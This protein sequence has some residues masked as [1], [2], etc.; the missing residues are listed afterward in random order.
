M[1][2]S[3]DQRIAA[4]TAEFWIENGGDA[5]GFCYNWTLVL[6]ELRRIEAEKA[7][8]DNEPADAA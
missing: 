1:A 2:N 7:E 6:E 8:A 5:E 4:A 3:A